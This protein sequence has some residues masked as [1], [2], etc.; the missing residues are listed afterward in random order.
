MEFNHHLCWLF[1]F[2]IVFGIVC[3]R[4]CGVQWQSRIFRDYLYSESERVV[5]GM[6]SRDAWQIWSGYRLPGDLRTTRRLIVGYEYQEKTYD[7]WTW[8]NDDSAFPKPDPITIS[9]I[10]LG[11]QQIADRYLVLRGFRSWRAQE[12]VALELAGTLGALGR[13][14]PPA[15]PLLRRLLPGLRPR[16]LWPR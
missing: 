3:Y 9:G 2:Y 14:E 1:L 13:R 10:R 12:D 16:R 8:E 11:Y 7:S 5:S 15:D 6:T 4:R